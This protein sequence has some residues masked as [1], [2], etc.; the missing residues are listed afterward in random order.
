MDFS[1]IQVLDLH[2]S[3]TRAAALAQAKD[4]ENVFDILQGVCILIISRPAQHREPV[5]VMRGDLWGGRQK[6][7]ALLSEATPAALVQ[8]HVNPKP[9]QWYFISLDLT[10][11]AEWLSCVSLLDAM[12]LN[13]NGLISA[14]DHFAYAFSPAEFERDLDVFLDTRL[15]DEQVAEQLD[16]RDNSMWS[17]HDARLRLRRERPNAKFC[18]VAYRPFDSRH[19][20]FHRD[21]IF[22]LRLPVTQHIIAGNNLVLLT[23][24][25]TKGDDWRHCFVTRYVS[26]CAFLS[27]QTS[28]NAFAF[29]L[30]R[31]PTTEGL[32][33]AHGG[34][35]A[36]FSPQFGARVRSAL[37]I[38]AST[39]SKGQVFTHEELFHYAYAV[40]HSREYRRRYAEFLRIDFPRLPLTSSLDLF[41]ALAA[42]GGELVALHLMES[43]KLDKHITK[44]TGCKNPEVEK[45]AHSD[46]TVWLDKAQTAGFRGVPEV[47]WNFHIGGYQV[48]EKWL[49]DR[50][51]RRL[52]ADDLRHYQKIVVALHETIRLMAEIDKTI[53]GH[54][55]W[56]N[57]FAPKPH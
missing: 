1:A 37:R 39:E 24:R 20:L 9:D 33:A 30:N 16:I 43:P 10:H 57:A 42:L 21:V 47:V 26:D 52:S 6:K 12:P 44:F 4:D 32:L 55:G 8:V 54:G 38:P 14:K 13:G 51:G 23:T 49:K 19:S 18:R 48:C 7:Y 35:E 46:E 34:Y 15:T 17:L 53:S 56:P 22:N 36:N 2:G 29:P 50:K 28:T 5:S 25:M 11:E 41:R 31:R 27:N 45:V 40:F 3:G